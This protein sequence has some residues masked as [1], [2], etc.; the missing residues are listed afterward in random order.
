MVRLWQRIGA[1]LCSR[2]LPEPSDRSWTARNSA[3]DPVFFGSERVRNKCEHRF[4]LQKKVKKCQKGMKAYES[5]R[6]DTLDRLH[7]KACKGE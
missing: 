2:P 4:V 3:K 6:P 1:I 7:R 5:I